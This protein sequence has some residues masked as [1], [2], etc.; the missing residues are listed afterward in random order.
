M[1]EVQYL[2]T[3]IGPLEIIVRSHRVVAI[4]F[5]DSVIPQKSDPASPLTHQCMQQLKQYFAG[6]RHQLC[7]PLALSS[8]PPFT[9]KCL[10]AL[11]RHAPYGQTLSYA[12]LASA[13]TGNSTYAR[14]IAHAL[15]VNPLAIAIPCHR[16]IASDGDLRGY[17]WKACRKKW[18][19]DFERSQPKT[20]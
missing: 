6:E 20:L 10:F 19:I 16:I 12:K 13:I 2:S 9:R 15:S 3:P 4:S 11:D 14:A 17:R 1:P 7:L 5:V 18:L 8:L